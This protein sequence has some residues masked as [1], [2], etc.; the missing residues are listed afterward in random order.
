MVKGKSS[1]VQE[2]SDTMVQLIQQALEKR[3]TATKQIEATKQLLQEAQG[4]GINTS[5]QSILLQKAQDT[6]ASS[7]SSLK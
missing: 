1:R 3:E 2:F 7:A 5:R 6:L 4:M